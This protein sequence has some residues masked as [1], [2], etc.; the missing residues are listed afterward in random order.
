MKTR[1]FC[2][3]MLTMLVL[4]GCGKKDKPDISTDSTSYAQTI[5]T[6]EEELR[7]QRESFYIKELAYKTE[8]EELQQQLA[9]LT[10]KTEGETEVIFRYRVENGEAIITGYSGNAALL[11]IP[12]ALDGYPVVAL[13]ERVFEGAS[14]AAVVLPE[15]MREIGWFAFYGCEQL[16]SVTLPA[17]LSS[18][19]YAVFDGCTRLSVFCPEG[20][21]AEQY[22]KSY[23]LSFVL[24]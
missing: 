5:A 9:T 17:S 22:A 11:S 20:S 14:I 16:V 12:E 21:Y 1:L 15:G 8:I 10:G 19:G 18:I 7:Q 23:G 6:L 3:L 2:F 13:G 24:I 4:T